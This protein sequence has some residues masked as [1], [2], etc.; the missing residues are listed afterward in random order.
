M[1]QYDPKHELTYGYWRCHTCEAEFYGGGPALHADGCPE[2][3]YKACVY[4]FGPNENTF[5]I[6]AVVTAEELATALAGVGDE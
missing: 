3:D 5:W 2:H 4:Y 1:K 6:G